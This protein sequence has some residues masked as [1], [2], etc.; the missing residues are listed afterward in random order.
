MKQPVCDAIT[1]F[2]VMEVLEK[3]QALEAAGKSV[4]HLEI[5]Q[6]DFVTPDCI[7][8]AAVKAMRD[9]HTGYTH[10]CGILPLREELAAYYEREYGVTVSPERIIV[11]N[12]TSAAMLL[13]FGALFDKGGTAVMPDP[14]YACYSNFVLFAGGSVTSVPAKE[15]EGFQLNVNEVKGKITPDTKAILVN[16]PSNPGG[17]IIAPEEF[18][19]LCAMQGDTGPRIVSDEIYH[20][21]V[22]EGRAASVLEF[23]DDACALDGF[24]KRYA[25]TGWRLGWMVIPQDLV[26]V[27]QK[28]QQNFFICAN[29][30]AQWAGI[31]A[32]KYAAPDVERMR[33]EYDRRRR[34]LL[35]GLRSLG[36]TINSD[37]VGA[38]YV[39]ANAK[40]LSN[41]SL[42]LAFDILEKAGVGVAPGIDFGPGAEGFLRFSYANSVENI[43][44]ALARLKKYVENT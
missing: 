25:M 22:Y 7:V 24:S 3:A 37:P 12:G 1:S 29:S 4:I 18:K 44:E 36:F 2:L 40:H 11:T 42:A 41:D 6:P 27:V 35:A 43:E 14:S 34:V 28:L 38:F 17:T 20:G 19:A 30:V 26:P 9:G 15:S 21:L 23:S 31:A 39:L 16:S 10:S 13:L 5:G 32:L 8:E 33:L